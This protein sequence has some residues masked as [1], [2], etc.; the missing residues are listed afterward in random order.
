MGNR[1]YSGLG[2]LGVGPSS[3]RA[4]P[5]R[6]GAYGGQGCEDPLPCTPSGC[7]VHRAPGAA[8][9]LL[10]TSLDAPNTA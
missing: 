2:R 3:R 7:P 9:F 6:R 4:S 5:W 8:A 1:L 10:G